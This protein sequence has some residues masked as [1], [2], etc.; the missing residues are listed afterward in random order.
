[1]WGLKLRSVALNSEHKFYTRLLQW[2]VCG[3]R[4]DVVVSM[5]CGKAKDPGSGPNSAIDLWA[6]V[7]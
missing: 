4:L 1:M 6:V 5:S 2:V 7:G 3:Q